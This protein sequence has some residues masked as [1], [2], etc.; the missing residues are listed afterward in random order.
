MAPKVADRLSR[1][2]TMALAG[3]MTLPNIMNSSTAVITAITPSASGSRAN[4]DVV[5][6]DQL[7]DCR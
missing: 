6:V 1:F 5:E 4:S 7:A 2:S 3:M